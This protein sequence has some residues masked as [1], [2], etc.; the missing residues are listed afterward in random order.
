MEL[1]FSYKIKLTAPNG[2]APS[3]APH[4]PSTDVDKRAAQGLSTETKLGDIKILLGVENYKTMIRIKQDVSKS[5]VPLG[6]KYRIFALSD[7]APEADGAL[8]IRRI[9]RTLSES[10]SF[11]FER[12][13][14]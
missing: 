1:S 13:L 7:R 12:F 3:V 2:C 5:H 10:Y 6:R 9:A 4:C 8:P 14:K 11:P